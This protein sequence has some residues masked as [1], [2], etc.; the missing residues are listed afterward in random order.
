MLIGGLRPALLWSALVGATLVALF[1]LDRA[2]AIGAPPS[3]LPATVLQF[4]SVIGLM[5][6]SVLILAL[7]GGA[8]AV[9]R[10]GK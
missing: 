10:R 6:L 1:V 2:G 5:A 7:A 3:G 4:A 9:E 8:A